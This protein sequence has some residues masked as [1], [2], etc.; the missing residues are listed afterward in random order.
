MRSSIQRWRKK[1]R[2]EEGF[3]VRAPR[4][5]DQAVEVIAHNEAVQ[6]RYIYNDQPF[7][8]VVPS[9]NAKAGKSFALFSTDTQR[10]FN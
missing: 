9:T 4:S 2:V 7:L 1:V 5:M 3:D 6:N 8:H 10:N